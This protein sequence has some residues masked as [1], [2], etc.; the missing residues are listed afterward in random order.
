[1]TNTDYTDSRIT[2]EFK[3]F[4][5]SFKQDNEYVYVK[6]IDGIIASSD[7][8]EI[9]YDD[10]NEVLKQIISDNKK[11]RIHQALYRAIKEVLQ[12][13]IHSSIDGF[14]KDN[15][16]KFKISNLDGYDEIFD[17]PKEHNEFEGVD[18]DTICDLNLSVQETELRIMLYLIK[19]KKIINR[20]ELVEKCEQTIFLK[21]KD[22]GKITAKE[23]HFV[24]ETKEVFTAMK[25]IAYELGVAGKP[26]LLEKKQTTEVAYWVLGKF[27]IKRIDLTG[28]VLFFNGQY[29][30]TH[31][32][33]LIRRSARDCLVNSS[34]GDMNE[35]WNY[36]KDISKVISFEDIML[37]SHIV[38]LLNGTYNIK[39]GEFVEEFS[40]ENIV[41][42]QVPHDYNPSAKYD[43]IEKIVSQIISD[44]KD[45]QMFYD[46][47]SLCF[48]PYNGV[49]MQYGGVGIAGTGKNQLVDLI[50]LALGSENVSGARIQDIANDATTQKDCAFKM[51][52]VDADLNDASVQ[53]IDT[54]KKWVTQDPMSGR[55]IYERMTTYRPSSRLIFM[56]NELY[57]ISNSDDAS[58]IYDRTYL[59]KLNNRVRHTKK[60]VKNVM[61]K[62]ATKTQL[63]GIIFYLLQNATWIAKHEKT[64]YAIN[65]QETKNTWNLFGN[66]LQM[67]YDKYFIASASAKTEKGK[68]F[69]KW[70][71]HAL[72]NNYQ[73]KD[74][75][76]FYEMFDEIVGTYPMKTR[77][78][79]DQVYAYSGFRLKSNDELKNETQMKLKLT[80]FKCD[81]CDVKYTTN[82]PLE[83]LRRFHK[84]SFPNHLIIE[85]IT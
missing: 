27:A 69:D 58:A 13:K 11:H 52:N 25:N 42:Q 31:A 83:L 24:L 61:Q 66:R 78:N 47:I 3:T 45:K 72:E 73:V 34:N 17:F 32:E 44:K 36:V 48:H 41:L 80:S 64:H 82:E 46:A 33:A 51:A 74:K 57:E 18:L 81:K 26:I 67:F 9:N 16:I 71:H 8:I 6:L 40:K 23:L 12:N 63:E 85:V 50:R 35:I 4:F 19:E 59:G 70:L 21:R 76:T 49:N 7:P 1:M 14:V 53:Q 65:P 5:N 38:V 37:F 60:E 55:G 56:A 30:D 68:V 15:L 62:T 39:T 10:F 84:E 20:N 43:D 77:I 29:Y 2:D 22:I 79:D 75:R 28:D 54:I